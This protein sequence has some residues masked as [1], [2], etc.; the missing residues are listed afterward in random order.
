MIKQWLSEWLL[1]NAKWESYKL[2]HVENKLRFDEKTMMKS[3]L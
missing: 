3:A 2:Y 1:F